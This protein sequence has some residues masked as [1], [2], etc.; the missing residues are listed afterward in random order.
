MTQ[1]IRRFYQTDSS[2]FQRLKGGDGIPLLFL[3]VFL[4]FIFIP[5]G[6]SKLNFGAQDIGF[7][8]Q[9][10]ANPQV[11]SWFANPD[12]GLGLPAAGLLAFL[13]GWSEFLGGW[14]LL[15]G[16]FT[17]LICIPLMITMIVAA[18]TA[19]WEQGW[20]VLPE[21]K[22]TVPW[23]WRT[24]LI[25]QANQRKSKANEVLKEHAD[26]QW[27]TETGAITILKNG[28]EFAAT[29]F[30]MLMVLFFYGGGRY[31]SLDHYLKKQLSK[32]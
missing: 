28:I 9:F 15:F 17:R 27:V 4:A 5:A 23:E 13:A 19:H 12:W 16:L 24:D 2:I 11:V 8:E 14:L 21:S 31:L 29:Y 3:R 20:H 7:F 18:T 25:E 22:L 6:Y 26:Y 1:L 10:L 30:L 32:N